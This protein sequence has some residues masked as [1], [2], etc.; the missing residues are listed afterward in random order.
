M[1]GFPRN[2][3]IR[4]LFTAFGPPQRRQFWQATGIDISKQAVNKEMFE[5]FKLRLA[6]HRELLANSRPEVQGERITKL[7]EPACYACG[8]ADENELYVT[9]PKCGQFC[10][11]CIEELI[12]DTG[13][14]A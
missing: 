6:G 11:R 7:S 8:R 14:V 5:A 1:P 3:K 10:A 2:A 13:S 9:V 12:R 4:K